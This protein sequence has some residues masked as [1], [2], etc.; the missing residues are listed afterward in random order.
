LTQ[1]FFK[2]W[3]LSLIAYICVLEPVYDRGKIF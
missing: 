1:N 3:L 2:Y